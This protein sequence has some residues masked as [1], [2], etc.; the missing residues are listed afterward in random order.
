MGHERKDGNIQTLEGWKYSNIGRMEI[1]KYSNIPFLI[2]DRN[3]FGIQ[4]KTGI[5]LK[6]RLLP[7]YITE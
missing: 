1:I 5:L 2:H 6:L 4:Y 7:N 3:S